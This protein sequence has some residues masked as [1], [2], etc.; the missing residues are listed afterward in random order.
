MS[1][2]IQALAPHLSRAAVLALLSMTFLNPAVHGQGGITISNSS[3]Q[4][5]HELD[6]PFYVQNSPSP[7]DGTSREHIRVRFVLAPNTNPYPYVVDASPVAAAS[8]LPL[9]FTWQY[10][11]GNDSDGDFFPL[12]GPSSSPYFTNYPSFLDRDRP[13]LMLVS[14]GSASGG[15]WFRVQVVTPASATEIMAEWLSDRA[16]GGDNPRSRLRRRLL[17]LMDEAS[18]RF[19][20]GDAEA[21]K[22]ELRTLLR[23]LKLSRSPLTL[24]QARA[25]KTL[26]QTIIDTAHN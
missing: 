17:P 13:K 8:A 26:S 4:V 21:G 2:L 9:T 11:V 15:L 10:Y 7:L 6:F 14:N 19:A 20:A 3:V 12:D 1:N 16:R 22:Q 5:L 25:V 18:A 23:R 24:A